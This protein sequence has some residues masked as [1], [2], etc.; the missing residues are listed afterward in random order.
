LAGETNVVGHKYELFLAYFFGF[1]L[2]FFV[3]ITRT[4]MFYVEFLH[5]AAD[6]TLV[7]SV[8]IGRDLQAARVTAGELKIPLFVARLCQC[9]K[10]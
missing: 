9:I 1:G 5:R 7:P 8:A 10:I 2:R 6:L 3:S 4:L